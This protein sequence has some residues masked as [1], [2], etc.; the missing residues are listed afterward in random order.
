M[1]FRKLNRTVAAL[2]VIVA[3][4]VT[5]ATA[6]AVFSDD[7]QPGQDGPR[8]LMAYAGGQQLRVDKRTQ[9]VATQTSS[10]VYVDLPGANLN[11]NVP[12][13][14]SR[15]FDVT[16]FAESY[17]SGPEGGFCSV[18]IIAPNVATNVSVELK[19]QA[20]LD[21]AFDSDME[22]GGTHD[23]WE[24]NGMERS[25]RLPGGPNGTTYKIRVRYAT[26]LNNLVFRLDD[27]HLTVAT[28]L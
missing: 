21:Y 6:A 17:C 27:W 4:G 16:F 28:N 18:T 1:N 14:Q 7:G 19:P 15:L 24:G 25:A 26:S 12:A 20:G 13:N 23:F 22:P 5:A 11:V 2:A 10:T 3:A 9:N 8:V